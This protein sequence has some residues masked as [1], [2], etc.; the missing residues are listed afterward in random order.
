[1]TSIELLTSIEG[2]LWFGI[3]PFGN[4]LSSCNCYSLEPR[5]QIP[6]LTIALLEE[7]LDLYY[8]LEDEQGIALALGALGTAVFSQG[9]P[10]RAT[11]L[12]EQRLARGR[13]TQGTPDHDLESLGDLMHHAHRERGLADAAQSHYAHHPTALLDQDGSHAE[14]TIARPA[15][16]ALKPASLTHV[17]AAA[18]PLAALTAW[19]ALFD[20]ADLTAGQAVLIHGAAGGAGSFAVRLLL[21]T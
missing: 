5:C 21:K 19:Q 6:G 2:N 9:D 17:E 4:S 15:D 18:V 13:I 12:L 14:Y 16:L 11:L 10:A 1:L 7:S 8:T 20:H 3:D